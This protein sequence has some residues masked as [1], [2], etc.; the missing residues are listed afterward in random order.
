RYAE[1][2]SI[3]FP[4]AGIQIEAVS[5][6]LSRDDGNQHLLVDFG[7]LY[8]DAVNSIKKTGFKIIHIKTDDDFLVSIQKLLTATDL[9]YTVDPTFLA[10]KRPAL[11]NTA[12]TIPGFL[13]RG[14]Q[15]NKIFLTA[16]PLPNEVVQFLNANNIEIIKLQ[17]GKEI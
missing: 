7:D 9:S 4:Y 17:K 16:V 3:T 15:E 13:L 11:Y 6:L 5:N 10:A 1:D 2:I 14:K 8:G 12:L